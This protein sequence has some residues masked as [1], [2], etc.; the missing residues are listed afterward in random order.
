MYKLNIRVE[1]C[2]W[3]SRLEKLPNKIKR[4]INKK[5]IVNHFRNPGKGIK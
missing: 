1:V 2:L 4:L 5:V 3:V